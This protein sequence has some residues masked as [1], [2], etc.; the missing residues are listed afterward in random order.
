MRPNLLAQKCEELRGKKVEILDLTHSNPTRA[1]IQYPE[2]L[3]APLAHP[4]GLLYEPVPKGLPH[5]REAVASLF[6]AKGIR[7]D[8]ERIVLTASTSEAYSHLFRLLTEPGGEVL[9]PRPSYPLF[10]YL[11]DLHD[12]RPVPYRLQLS[13]QGR[14]E[15]DRESLTRAASHRTQAFIAVQP[16]NPTGSCFNGPEREEVFRFCREQGVALISDEVFAEYLFHKEPE[17]PATLLGLD[18]EVLV[19]SL[20]GLSKWM[21]LPQMKLGWIAVGGPDPKAGEALARLEMIA[22]T[23]LSVNTVVQMALPE[24]LNSAAQIQAQILHRLHANRKELESLV[25]H[26]GGGVQAL[27]SQGGWYAVLQVAGVRDEERWAADLL[28]ER[29]VLIHPGYLFNFEKPGTAILSLLPSPEV[30]A[31]GIRRL[32]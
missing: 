30:F 16:N 4:R 14:W 21:G 31:E 25:S 26:S 13:S 22:D 15:L 9:V 1:G 24:W 19:F 11:A 6:S 17:A 27:P 18:E 32:L 12:V 5:A 20:G 23:A 28:E 29:H 2:G 7:L 10:D 3:L 8:P